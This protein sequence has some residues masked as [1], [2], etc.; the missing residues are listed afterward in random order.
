MGRLVY[1]AG[2]DVFRPDPVGHGAALK[3]CCAAHGLVGVYPLDQ[4]LPP[5]LSGPAMGAA[6]YRGNVAFIRDCDA[7]LANLTPFRG[8]SADA[9]TVFEVG[10]AAALGKPVV[11]YTT[12]PRVYGERV[13]PDGWEIEDFGL[14]D[15]LMIACALTALEP[16]LEGALARLARLLA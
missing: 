3:A 5:G 10:Y 9:G 14:A 4:A 8:P 12:D 13:T 16:D 7:V 11:G 6:I 15:N 1:L 2:P